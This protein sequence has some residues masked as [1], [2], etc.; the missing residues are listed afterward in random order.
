MVGPM[1]FRQCS[2]SRWWQIWRW[3]HEWYVTTSYAALNGQ[4]IVTQTTPLW[5]SQMLL[6]WCPERCRMHCTRC[7]EIGMDYR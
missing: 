7:G 1:K 3:G 4:G 6:A 2:Q 5:A